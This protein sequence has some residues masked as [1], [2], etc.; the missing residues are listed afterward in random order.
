MDYGLPLFY[1]YLGRISLWVI[2]GEMF[3]GFKTH[4]PPEYLHYGWVVW[5]SFY[6]LSAIIGMLVEIL[7]R[8]RKIII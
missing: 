7:I 8:H 4:I 1:N 6:F 5:G 3:G 2:A